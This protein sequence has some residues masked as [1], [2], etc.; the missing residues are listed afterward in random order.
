MIYGQ[1]M[2]VAQDFPKYADWPMDRIIERVDALEKQALIGRKV[3]EFD[4]NA[5]RELIEGNYRI[6]YIVESDDKIGVA[7]IHHSA[8]SLRGL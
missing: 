3:P 6:I 7:F 1:Y 5:I 2:Y 8:R 4:N